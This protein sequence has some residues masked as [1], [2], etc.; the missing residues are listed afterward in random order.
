MTIR[1]QKTSVS[2]RYKKR[3]LYN[4]D[5]DEETGFYYLRARYY[6]PNIQ[7]FISEDPAKDGNNWY[8]YCANNPIMFIDPTGFAA[9]ERLGSGIWSFKNDWAGRA[10]LAHW[11]FGGGK[12]YVVK[13][14]AWGTYMKNNKRSPEN[15]IKALKDQMK[16]ILF[17]K[18]NA[19]EKGSSISID[20]T[21]AI[22]IENGEDI[23]GYQYLHGTNA[24][25]GGFQIKG[26]ISKNDDGDITYELT[27]TWND[28]IDPNFIYS[29][30]RKKAEFAEKIPFADPTDYIIR[31]S[32]TDKT[33]IKA[34]P[35]IF[36]WNS[37][38]L[39]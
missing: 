6:D 36:N 8:I 1:R 37:G 39:K 38:W 28:K 23:I 33:G 29:S 22:T 19:L 16:D 30:D 14:G 24:D 4:H 32:W 9:E 5:K 35:G 3:S 18:G 17:P 15:G 7:R 26:T 27:Y 10:I 31:I 2:L 11:L 13:N 25:V 12:E 21:T 34:N 20:I